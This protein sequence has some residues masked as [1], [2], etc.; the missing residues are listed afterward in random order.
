MATAK[1]A[2]AC[3]LSPEIVHHEP[4]AL[5]M[6]FV[7]ATTLTEQ[8]VQQP[9]TLAR[10]VEVLKRCHHE[11]PN[12]LRGATLMF[13]VFQVCRNYLHTAAQGKSRVASRLAELAAVNDQL[14]KSVGPIQPAFCHNDLLPANFLD[15]GSKLWLLDW[16]YAGWNTPLFDLANLATNSQLS[17]EQEAGLLEQYFDQPAGPELLIRM[18]ALACASLLRE[19]LWS[20]VQEQHSTLDIDYAQYTDTNLARFDLA[21]ERMANSK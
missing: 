10:V 14:E 2:H 17:P 21:L 11:M 7:D 5:V 1:A 3:G 13:W 8:D 9:E 20:I 12:Q 16:E 18:R 4:G 15:D 19:S 6:R